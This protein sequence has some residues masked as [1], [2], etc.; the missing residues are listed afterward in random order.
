[1]MQSE[2]AGWNQG[3]MGG[4]ENHEMAGYDLAMQFQALPMISLLLLFNDGDADFPAYTTVL[5]QRQA[6]FYLDPES[7]AMTSA[8]LARRLTDAR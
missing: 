8:V 7:L 3:E 6:E 2:S 1:M 5:F 4:V